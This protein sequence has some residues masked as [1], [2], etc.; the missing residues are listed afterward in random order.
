MKTINKIF[1]LIL[2]LFPV[3]FSSC[4]KK[5]NPTTVEIKDPDR[6]YYAILQGQE[7]ELLYSILNTGEDPLIIREIQPSCG[8]M[9]VDKED[10]DIILPHKK[11]YVRIKY[12]STKNVGYVRHY[13]RIYG[14]FEKKG[15]VELTFDVNV[16][17]DADYTRDYE[18]LFRASNIKNGIVNEAVDGKESE[19]GYYV[20]NP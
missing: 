8:C 12:N 20:G 19:R 5:V 3:M 18:E 17:P 10:H 11:G 15:M 13:I 1:L 4:Q 16:V 7:L 14:N 9:I 6:H 2:I